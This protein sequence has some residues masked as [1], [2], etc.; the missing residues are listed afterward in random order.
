M[1]RYIFRR[2]LSII[3]TLIG[4]TFVIFMFQRLIPGDPAIAML[5]EHA[6]DES[7]ERIR[8]QFG[9]NRPL[10]LD[11]EALDNGD[12]AGFFDSQYI[13]Y[14]GRLSRLDLGDSIHRRIPVMETLA[15]RFPATVELS[16]LSMILAVIVGIPVGIV[17]ASRRNS[18]I[19][20]IS[21]VGSLIGV[22]MPIFWL[23]LMEIMLF[24]V[25]LQWLPAGAR[26][27]TGIKIESITS[28]YLIDS[29][30]TGNFKGFVDVLSHI[31]LPAIALAT[32]PMAIIARMTRSSMLDVLQE[33][34]IRTAKAK[35]LG[36]QL[37]LYR[38]ALKNAALPVVT[39][40]GLQAGTLLAGAVLTETIFSWPGIGRW[41]YD[42][43]LGRDYPIVQGGT[44]LIAIVFIGVNF[45]VDILYAI[46][47]PRIRYK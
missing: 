36:G 2:I 21:M 41:V 29:L 34:Y 42:A 43:I 7:I 22:S 19:D 14:M 26:L 5:G 33:D 39:I 4:V 10:F 45:L 25:I 37:V 11:R 1:I 46:L 24:A 30:I 32:I 6:T 17:S 27:S 3:P 9:L 35:G 44:L 8:E 28:L 16:L 31:I 13:L 18:A 20:S 23:G 47:D 12:V 38:H 40:I 15:L